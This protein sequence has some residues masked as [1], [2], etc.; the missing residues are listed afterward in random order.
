APPD[1]VI[2]TCEDAGVT[3]IYVMTEENQLLSFYPPTLG[4]TGIGKIDCPAD[5]GATPFSM[6]VDRA[7]IAYVVFND[8]ELFRVSTLTASC[9]PTGFTIN[10]NGF[11]TVF[12]M[13]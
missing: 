6:A 11:P 12:G 4:F 1:V 3:Y 2:N 5:P 13:G 10:Q 7:G 9:K 8:G